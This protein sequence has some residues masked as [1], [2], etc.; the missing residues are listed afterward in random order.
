[1]VNGA[2]ISTSNTQS[3]LD[4]QKRLE[5]HIAQA[6]APVPVGLPTLS[7]TSSSLSTAKSNS[8]GSKHQNDSIISDNIPI[9]SSISSIATSKGGSGN[10]NQISFSPSEPSGS[11]PTHIFQTKLSS[12][13]L[14]ES[15]SSIDLWESKIAPKTGDGR[16]GDGFDLDD[17]IEKPTS[18]NVMEGLLDTPSRPIQ[19]D[20]DHISATSLDACSVK[21]DNEYNSNNSGIAKLVLTTKTTSVNTSSSETSSNVNKSR[22]AA[23]CKTNNNQSLRNNA[24]NPS[25]ATA[26][27]ATASSAA[28]AAASGSASSTFSSSTPSVITVGNSGFDIRKVS[29]LLP[30]Q[31]LAIPNKPNPQ[32]QSSH[33][34]NNSK[35]TGNTTSLSASGGSATTTNANSNNCSGTTVTFSASPFSSSNPCT[36]TTSVYDSSSL[37]TAVHKTSMSRTASVSETSCNNSSSNSM[38]PSGNGN[39][40]KAGSNSNSSKLSS[41]KKPLVQWDS[42]ESEEELSFFPPSKRGVIT[43]N[44]SID[45]MSLSGE[46][47]D[48]HL[49]PPR[50]LTKKCPCDPRTWLERNDISNHHH[51]DSTHSISSRPCVIS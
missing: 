22:K 47:E 23:T 3:T 43:D 40:I 11:A 4:L 7:H 45:N 39:A 48:L 41:E 6:T 9:P 33:L 15:D 30:P 44:L 16:I 17:D 20:V 31:R 28:V 5:K 50:P 49:T 2:A 12:S 1:M 36:T 42:D 24:T 26:G 21:N 37:S 35:T 27:A 10:G 18:S 46:E 38:L 8:A 29:A 34:T 19:V 25:N 51:G 13:S 32:L 14:W